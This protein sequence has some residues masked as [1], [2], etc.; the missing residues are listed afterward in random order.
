MKR[1][2]ILHGL[3]EEDE[4]CLKEL[5]QRADAT[6][7]ENAGNEV[8]LRGL[9]EISSHCIRQCGYC[10]LRSGNKELERYRMN[11]EEILS[12]VEEAEAYGYGTVVLQSG[13]SSRS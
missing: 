12:C 5:W 13:E 9:I 10:G 11:E 1:D 8:H 3:L 2:E 7:G 4:D 6:R